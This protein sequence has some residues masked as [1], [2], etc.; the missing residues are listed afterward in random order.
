MI[1]VRSG[2]F[3]LDAMTIWGQG[4]WLLN[5]GGKNFFKKFIEIF[6]KHSLNACLQ[7]KQALVVHYMYRSLNSNFDPYFC[8]SISQ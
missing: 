2:G 7:N 8:A 5:E 4:L 3:F 1:T 6:R